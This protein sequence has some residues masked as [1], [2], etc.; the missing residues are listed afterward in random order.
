M[1]P[2]DLN[3]V[4]TIPLERR[5]NKVALA[6]FAKPPEAGRSFAEFA[7]SLPGILVGNDFRDVVASIAAAH[8]NR[9]PVIV[10]MGAHVVKCGLNPVLIDLMR[11]GIVT[12]IALNGSGAIHDFEIAL[13][14]ETSEDVAAGL[15]D[16][17][18][19]MVR[20]TGELFNQGVNQVLEHRDAGMGGLLAEQLERIAAPHREYSLLA[21]GRRLNVPVTV[22]VAIGTD[23]VHMHPSA[24][25]AALG[26]ATFND[27]RIFA[28]AVSGLSGGVYVNIGSAVLLPEV[29]L[30]AFTIAQNIGAG[31]KDYVTVNMD[32][33]AHYRPG[34]NV[35]RRPAGVGGK[36]YPLLGRHEIM[37]PL[38]AQAVVDALGEA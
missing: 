31:L 32:M 37:V 36:S 13:I 25:G 4:R 22:H 16:G 3:R 23:I 33:T 19:G 8:R 30:K 17:T 2:V 6:G 27:F 10:G 14:G 21:A 38:L 26:L 20:E 34:E 5:P 9:R 29:F 7:S 35:L 1:Q 18:F 28:A 11:R 15:K 24:D 12:A